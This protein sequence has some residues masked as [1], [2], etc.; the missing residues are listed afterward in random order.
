MKLI[1]TGTCLLCSETI[2]P[3]GDWYSLLQTKLPSL[4]SACT[5]KLAPISQ[6][7]CCTICGHPDSKPRCAACQPEDFMQRSLYPYNDDVKDVLARYK[8][9]GDAALAALFQLPMQ[10]LLR[11]LPKADAVVPVPLHADRLFERGFNQAELVVRR[12]KLLLAR[13][14]L[15]A[16][17]SKSTPVEREANLREAFHVTGNVTGMR[18]T[19]VDDIYTTGATMRACK[20]VLMQAGA[21]SVCGITVARSLR[22]SPM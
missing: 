15:S 22:K 2:Y 19:L 11:R 21:V 6:T 20:D 17:Q 12:P 13:R 9:R 14:T 5:A 8:Y 1:V 16:K 7:S 3:A 10:R 18:I 4:C